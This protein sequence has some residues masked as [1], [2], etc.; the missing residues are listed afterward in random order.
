MINYAKGPNEGHKSNLKEDTLQ[1]LNDNFIQMILDRV[2]Q[3]VQETLKKAQDNKNR[4]FERAKEEIKETIEAL[5]KHQ[6]ETENTMNKQ[7]NEIRT[8]IDNI[9]EETTQDMENLRKKNKTDLKNKMEGQ[10]SRIEQTE[11]RISELK[12]EMVIKGKTKEPLIKQLKTCQKKMQDLT[13]SI[14][15]PNLRIIGIEEGEEVQVKRMCNIL[16][17]IIMENFPNL[18]KDIPIQIQEASRTPNRPDQNRTTT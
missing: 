11:D 1:L 13:N 2:K 3:N 8:K 7:I 9:K 14:K 10:S 17:K 4:E 12:D 18:E 5:Y 6:S 16:K 15:R